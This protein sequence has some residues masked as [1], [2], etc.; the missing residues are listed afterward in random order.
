[1][2]INS[3]EGTDNFSFDLVSEFTGYNSSRD[4]TNISETFFV[5][6]SKNV[7]K[8]ISGTIANR[9]G[10][11]RRG[12]SDDTLA[13]VVSSYE[14]YNSLGET[15]PMRVANNKLQVE[16]DI[17]GDFLWY[18]LSTTGTVLSPAAT[19]TRFVFDVWWDNTE[20]KDR[21]FM[22]RGD[23][24]LL[25]WSGGLTLIS[26]V[27]TNTLT[28]T[29]TTSWASSGFATNTAGEKK[30][31]ILGVEYTYTGGETTT[32][33]TGVTPDPALASPAI[34]VSAVATQ[35][36]IVTATTP[37]TGFN[38]DFLKVINNQIYCGSYNSRT[39]YVSDDTTFSNFTEPSPHT[40]GDPFTIILDSMPKGIGVR[41]GRAHIFAGTSDLYIV[42]FQQITVGVVMVEQV[43]VDKKVI[44]GLTS[45]LG[46]EFIDSVG[47]ILIW[48]SQDQ[49]LRT[50]G[51]YRD[52]WEPAYPSLSQ[53]I[54]T[55]LQEIDFTGG[56]VRA[57]SDFVYITSPN[58]GKTYLFQS[59]QSIDTDGHIITE[60]VWHAPM[61]WNVSRIAEIDGVVYGHSN[62]NP[63]IYQ[64]W[65]TGQWRDD[66]PSDEGLSYDSV[67]RM[68]Y[69][70][71]S[72]RQGL[73]S[74]SMAYFEGYATEGTGLNAYLISDYQGSLGI[75][76]PIILDEKTTTPNQGKKYLSFGATFPS[77]GD[78]SIGDNPLGDG[79]NLESQDQETL[80]KFRVVTD[81][82]PVNCFEYQLVVYSDSI[83]S[84]WEIVA[85]GT[86]S[87]VS[88]EQ[89]A[90][91]IRR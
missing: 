75:Q 36:V 43:T 25:H 8:K 90:T 19:Y 2:A 73:I 30:I 67:V 78:A 3:Q 17:T 50:Y 21:L 20:K 37:A 40:S 44:S 7:Y 58:L 39:I 29:G 51:D 31:I 76:S 71:H 32:T 42:T 4:K 49:Q 53:S 9:C 59:R 77:I 10:V 27:G 82:Q 64:L 83:D 89:Q 46:H 22:V 69:R 1:M 57:I 61:I 54:F 70:S 38:S 41:Q 12:I 79:L 62:A 18:D 5:R 72:R 85:L 74:M 66:S 84:R 60:R 55:E 87:T 56:H 13:G 91:F 80:P 6:G 88:K 24:N 63:Q 23:S 65:D 86:N 14:W 26:S 35:S 15:L 16:S 68:A 34:S 45:A 33:L 28:K 48:L 52:I 11:K 47:D 81:L